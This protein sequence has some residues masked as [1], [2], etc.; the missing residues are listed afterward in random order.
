MAITVEHVWG[1]LDAGLR[2]FIH[3]RVRDPHAAE[4]VLQ[5]VYL[6]IHARIHTLRDEEKL[7]AWVYRVARNAINDHYRASRPSSEL[8][9]VPYTPDDPAD[10]EV[11]RRLSESVRRCLDYLS[12]EYREALVLTEYEGLT[13]AQI[14]GRLGLSVSGAKSRVQRA[15]ARL[16]EL[17]LECCHFELDRA[18][19]VINYKPR[20]ACCVDCGDGDYSPQSTQRSGM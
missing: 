14:A 8:G 18:G 16:K 6:K 4:D 9:E 5:D 10:E 2:A 7:H 11:G 1:E 20:A 19:R 15:R 12:P 13:Q 3:A 17:L